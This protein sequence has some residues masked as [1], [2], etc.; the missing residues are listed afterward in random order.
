MFTKP[1]AT[2]HLVTETIGQE[3]FSHETHRKRNP[4]EQNLG[5]SQ[6][7]A[8][9]PWGGKTLK[10]AG[11]KAAKARGLRNPLVSFKPSLG[12]GLGRLRQ[13]P[14]CPAGLFVRS[15]RNQ[16]SQMT[17][18]RGMVRHMPLRLATSR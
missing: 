2:E 12:Q 8:A 3:T 18:W 11:P 1:A 14:L 9:T 5:L 17:D 16:S 6:P 4:G 7:Q 15:C 13:K 10:A